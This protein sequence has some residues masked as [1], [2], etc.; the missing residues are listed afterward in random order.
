VR[1]YIAG[2]IWGTGPDRNREAFVL[3]AKRIQNS[4][5]A[6]AVIPHDIEPREHAGACPP[7]RRSENATH[8][9]GCYLRADITEMLTCDGIA[10]MPGWQQSVGART[11]LHVATAC[12]LAVYHLDHNQIVRKM[13]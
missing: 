1:I 6:K 7:G 4:L 12:G 10:L 5:C 2:P 13:V 9:E 8:N 3:M 11:E